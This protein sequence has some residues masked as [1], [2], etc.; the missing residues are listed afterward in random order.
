MPETTTGSACE[1]FL[2]GIEELPSLPQVVLRALHMVRSPETS[3]RDIERVI[4]GDQ[5]L[6]GK[7][8]RVSNSAFYGLP[9]TVTSVREAVVLL[10]CRRIS[11][12]IM[13]I[14]T[15]GLMG[16]T[17]GDDQ[18]IRVRRWRHA[19]MSACCARALAAS[20][21]IMDQDEAFTLGLLHDIGKLILDDRGGEDYVAAVG[22]AEDGGLLVVAMEEFVLGFNHADL[23]GTLVTRWGLSSDVVGAVL[24]HHAPLKAPPDVARS[25]AVAHLADGMAHALR[26]TVTPEGR[27]YAPA[28]DMVV[29]L[30][31]D[32]AVLSAWGVE[33]AGLRPLA[34][35][36]G[37]HAS[38]QEAFF[39]NL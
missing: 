12:L 3:A 9:R 39:R 21:G 1:Q 34:E 36:A 13:G 20:T 26:I 27:V 22:A 35:E 33:E 16:A 31:V 19:L 6:A 10:G 24:H 28:E 14:A 11:A 5:A 2:E 37:R 15:G 7:V 32:P 25:A 8:L 38:E 23:G 18:L 17:L 30:H 29:P 4:S